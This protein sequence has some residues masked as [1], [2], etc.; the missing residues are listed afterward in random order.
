MEYERIFLWM[1]YYGWLS[2]CS[3]LDENLVDSIIMQIAP[4]LLGKGI[5]LFSQKEVLKRFRLKRVKK[6]EQFAELVFERE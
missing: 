6:Y 3:L 1:R 2:G 4:V 5:P